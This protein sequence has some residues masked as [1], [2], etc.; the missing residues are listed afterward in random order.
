MA[1]ANNAELPLNG[2]YI[3][4]DSKTPGLGLRVYA[5]GK[6]SWIFQK[7]LGTKPVKLVLG[8]APSLPLESK[9]N[10]T[11]GETLK[12]ARQLAEEAAAL[13]RQGLDPRLEKKKKLLKTISDIS[14]NELTIKKAWDEYVE[15]KTL[16]PIGKPKKRTV[17]D[18]SRAVSKLQSSPVWNKSLLDLTGEDL[19]KEI[20]RLTS[21]T[22]S[23]SA[24]TGGMTQASGIMRYLRAVYKYTLLNHNL[25]IADDPFN[26]LNLLMP[27]WQK[28][29]ARNRRI[30]E[31]EG[32]MKAWWEAVDKLR[33]RDNRDSVAIADWLQLSVFF[34]T[35]KT[36][37]LSLEWANVDLK[38]KII[39]LPE[40]VTKGNRAHVIPMTEYVLT[41]INRRHQENIKRDYLRRDGTHVGKSDWVFQ[42][43][44]KGSVTGAI[45]HIVSPSKSINQIIESTGIKFS[46]HDL[47]RTFA[48]LLNE[49]GASHFTIENALNHAPDS[50]AA[51]SY[52]NN[53]RILK[54]REIFQSLED[55]IL[56]EAGVKQ[57]QPDRIEI[58]LEDYAL[59]LKL[60]EKG[61]T[62]KKSTSSRP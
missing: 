51:K 29:N 56:I 39:I 53:P 52:V 54:L 28:T 20:I 6:K 1:V 18:W 23:S 11:T 22:T 10:P 36:E 40:D 8:P 14:K 50:V 19:K 44:R 24:T 37:L 45:R 17:D 30:G 35:R 47:R 34:G 38:N 31:T 62:L 7:K 16:L 46:P 3:L 32:S 42:A 48:T 60:K 26:R 43:S 13:I 4:R 33:S 25:F 58:S 15:H 12:G 2:D 21:S 55:S 9:N 41:I 57:A 61:S 5:S 27:G 59:L 49:G